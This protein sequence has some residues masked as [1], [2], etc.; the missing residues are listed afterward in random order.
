[1]PCRLFGSYFCFPARS[2]TLLACFWAH[3]WSLSSV[4][5]SV[6][7]PWISVTLTHSYNIPLRDSQR[8][9]S[10][11]LFN[12]E[13]LFSLPCHR[14]SAG[15]WF[16]QMIQIHLVLLTWACSAPPASAKWCCL[17]GKNKLF[18]RDIQK[19][20]WWLN[21]GWE[22]T[23]LLLKGGSQW[24]ENLLGWIFLGPLTF[25]WEAGNLLM[26]KVNNG[27]IYNLR[28]PWKFHFLCTVKAPSIYWDSP[29]HYMTNTTRCNASSCIFL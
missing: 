18:W 10:S 23:W 20:L 1:M 12:H 28:W 24:G 3:T 22:R 19:A 2:R 17:P 7:G 13:W 9:S 6:T 15:R 8:S 26:K 25:C 4:R 27:P 29:W 11:A 21:C 16:W 5:V 14:S